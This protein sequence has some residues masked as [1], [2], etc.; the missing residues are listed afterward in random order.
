MVEGSWNGWFKILIFAWK[1]FISLFFYLSKRNFFCHSEPFVKLECIATFS[2]EIIFWR[3]PLWSLG[4]LHIRLSEYMCQFSC[5]I[6]LLLLLW[7]TN[8]WYFINYW[9][10]WLCP[11][12]ATLVKIGDPLTLILQFSTNCYAIFSLH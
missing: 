10:S 12:F 5:T 3:P 8:S 11:P 2:F 1:L 9:T 4:I 7:V 6:A